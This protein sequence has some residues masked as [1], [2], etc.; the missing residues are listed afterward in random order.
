MYATLLFT[1]LIFAA[2]APRA[3]KPAK[4]AETSETKEARELF[5]RA[6]KLYKQARYAEAIEKFEAAYAVRPHP[7]I[8]FNIGKC[9]EQLNETPKAL[10]AYR[11]YL[12][13]AP[14]A[15]DRDTVTD[16][17]AN[18]ERRLKDRGVQQLLVFA[19]PAQARIEVDGKDLGTSPASIELPAG[20]HQLTVRADGYE[21]VTRS[22]VMSI[23]RATE[24]TVNLRTAAKDGPPPSPVVD[25][26]RDEP[27]ATALVP[28]AT[29]PSTE[30]TKKVEPA[31]AKK[32][33]LWTWVASGVAVASAGAATGLGVAANS[34]ASDLRSNRQ[35]S[36]ADADALVKGAENKALGANVMWG[37]AAG[38]AIT[39]VVLFFVE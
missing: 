30:L 4:T 15:T 29:E 33:R 9:Y 26:P 18:L 17:I 32:S 14:D 12:R 20:N 24:M 37:V 22:F 7:V 27:K 36:R 8:F 2:P 31:P 13:M 10:R 34:D 21:T 25:V 39:A 11:D 1:A 28:A 35:P 16:A 5:Q 38:A 6:Q 19:D 23:T 3:A